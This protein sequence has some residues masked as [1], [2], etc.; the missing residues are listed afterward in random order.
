MLLFICTTV[1]GVIIT[2]FLGTHYRLVFWTL[3]PTPVMLNIAASPSFRISFDIAVGSIFTFHCVFLLGS[4]HTTSNAK[5]TL[6][7]QWQKC[8]SNKTYNS[9]DTNICI[10]FKVIPFLIHLPLFQVT[11]LCPSYLPYDPVAS[12]VTNVRKNESLCVTNK[13]PTGM[14]QINCVLDLLDFWQVH[15]FADTADVHGPTKE[16]VFAADNN[17]NIFRRRSK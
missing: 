3:W 17:N 5:R 1:V 13:F 11:V 2:Y 15:T 9:F 6:Y 7:V 14:L 10:I 12:H 4:V 16:S 8:H